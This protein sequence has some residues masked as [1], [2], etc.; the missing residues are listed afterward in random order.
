[1]QS[2]RMEGVEN[3]IRQQLG[4]SEAALS[5]FV[6]ALRTASAETIATD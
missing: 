1:M 5:A 6:A 4:G 3:S 2:A